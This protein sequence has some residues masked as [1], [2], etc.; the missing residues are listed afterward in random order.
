MR[1]VAGRLHVSQSEGGICAERLRRKLRTP[2]HV[3]EG[4]FLTSRVYKCRMEY[5]SCS[6]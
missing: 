3:G 6:N 1:A 2:A 4:T 5:S